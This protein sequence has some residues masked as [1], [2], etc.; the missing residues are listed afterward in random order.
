[1]GDI[2]S[3]ADPETHRELQLDTLA[4]ILPMD[5]SD[6]RGLRLAGL[7]PRECS[8]YGLRLPSRTC[9]PRCGHASKQQS[10]YKSVQQAASY[11]NDGER[12]LGRAVRMI[13]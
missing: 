8:A 1:M 5:R 4:A 3:R 12:S 9:A 2:A 13:S 7:D 11:Y 6:E 10:Q